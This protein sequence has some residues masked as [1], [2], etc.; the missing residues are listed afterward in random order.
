[1]KEPKNISQF[2]GIGTYIN[3]F[4]IQ[5]A[6]NLGCKK[7]DFLEGDYNWKSKF[8]TPVPLYC[9]R[10]GLTKEEIIF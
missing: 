6:I 10:K 1:M 7:I 8:L 5:D 9:F 3:L 4:Q 2:P